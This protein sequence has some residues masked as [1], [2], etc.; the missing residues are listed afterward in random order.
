MGV[1]KVILNRARTEAMVILDTKCFTF[2]H[3][4]GLVMDLVTE[5][6]FEPIAMD[7]RCDEVTEEIEIQLSLFDVA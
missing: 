7:L 2:H 5:M 6:I 4:E 3:D 1:R